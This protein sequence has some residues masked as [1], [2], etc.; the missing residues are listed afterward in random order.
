M[1][2]IKS[3]GLAP[4]PRSIYSGHVSVLYAFNALIACDLLPMYLL[5]I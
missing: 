3:G 5:G 4:S 1:L 2:M